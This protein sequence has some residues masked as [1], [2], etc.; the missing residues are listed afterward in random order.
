MAEAYG[1]RPS[2]LLGVGDRTLGFLL[3]EALFVR[4]RLW[5]AEQHEND[6]SD[7]RPGGYDP[8]D[9]AASIRVP[10]GGDGPDPLSAAGA[11]L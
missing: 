9:R 11:A 8:P 2:E 5:L 4:H 7:Y 3:D 1:T 6:R 10:W